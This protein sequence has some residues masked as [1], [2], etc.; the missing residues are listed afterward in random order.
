MAKVNLRVKLKSNSETSDKEIEGKIKKNEISYFDL[1]H[2]IK[3]FFLNDQIRLTKQNK[4]YKITI[5]LIK[6][7]SS[8]QYQDLKSGMV[9]NM[10]VSDE[11]L[12]IED[13]YICFKY[14]LENNNQ[15]EYE[16]DYE[17]L[18]ENEDN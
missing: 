6:N 2:L 3:L 13:G 18:C 1:G 7:N 9:L 17:V 12:L 16:L 11:Y 14:N 8:C 15:I 10:Q 4:D 5:K